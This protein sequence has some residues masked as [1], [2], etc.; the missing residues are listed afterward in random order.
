MFNLRGK[1]AGNSF[2]LL[3]FNHHL[4]H[5]RQFGVSEVLFPFLVFPPAPYF[6][7]LSLIHAPTPSPHLHAFSGLLFFHHVLCHH[8]SP[9]SYSRLCGVTAA[10]LMVWLTLGR[11]T[12]RRPDELQP[13]LNPPDRRPD[14]DWQPTRPWAITNTRTHKPLQGCTP[15]QLRAQ[16]MHAQTSSC[17]QNTFVTGYTSDAPTH[18]A[19]SCCHTQDRQCMRRPALT[20]IDCVQIQTQPWSNPNR[21]GKVSFITVSS[22]VSAEKAIWMYEKHTRL[23]ILQQKPIVWNRLTHN[24]VYWCWHGSAE[25]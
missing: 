22:V 2:S 19:K 16:R 23:N 8:E 18:N 1:L 20:V 3:V 9:A 12:K 11:S 4:D 14:Q 10:C 17:S 7:A 5:H 21:T 15:A 6:T 25:Q 13:R 24:W